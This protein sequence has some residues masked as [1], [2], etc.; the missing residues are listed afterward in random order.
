M[1]RW[2]RRGRLGAMVAM[3]LKR[4]GSGV[5]V[6]LSSSLSLSVALVLSDAACETAPQNKRHRASSEHA[7]IDFVFRV[8]LVL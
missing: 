5:C 8:W 1:K 6:S 7:Y 2:M 4:V 3:G